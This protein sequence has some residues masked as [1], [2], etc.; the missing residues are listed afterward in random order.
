MKKI[1]YFFLGVMREFIVIALFLV[2]LFFCI[3][4]IKKYIF[5]AWGIHLQWWFVLPLYF[6]VVIIFLFLVLLFA[7]I[8]VFF[9]FGSAS[10]FSI[11]KK[12]V[13]FQKEG[14]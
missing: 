1:K 4:D 12:I 7:G 3:V 14:N 9:L 5:D 11:L 8:M 10:L 13:T 2:P 6:I